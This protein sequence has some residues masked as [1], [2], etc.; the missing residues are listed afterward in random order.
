MLPE[1]WN[2]VKDKLFAALELEGA[3]RTAYLEEIAGQGLPRALSFKI[4]TFPFR[5]VQGYRES[6]TLLQKFSPH[7][8]L[9]MGGYLSVP[10]ILNARS[11]GI[12]TLLHE[13]NVLPGLANRFLSRWADSVAVSFSVPF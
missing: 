1:R 6:R 4:F 12:P 7:A 8:V 11:L 2:V 3:E 13:Q 9:S 5:L 10:V